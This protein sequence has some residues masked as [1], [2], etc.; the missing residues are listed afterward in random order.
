MICPLSFCFVHRPFA[1]TADQRIVH[2]GRG[3]KNMHEA[4]VRLNTPY[5]PRMRKDSGTGNRYPS[6]HTNKAQLGENC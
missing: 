6:L 3:L 5:G 4:H 2:H 1:Y